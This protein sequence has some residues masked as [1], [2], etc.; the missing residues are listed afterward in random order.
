[1]GI[2]K[3]VNLLEHTI[4]ESKMSLLYTKNKDQ[5]LVQMIAAEVHVGTQNVSEQMSNYVYKRNK[6][7]IHYMDVS[8]TW[9]KLM[10]A[11][12]VIA[13][14]QAKNKQDVLIV[15]SRQYAQRAILKFGYPHRCQLLGW[16][17]GSR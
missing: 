1:M 12:R 10:V 9:E 16:K 3:V 17:V 6:D 8:K 5:D 7:G 4:N 2:I 14:P 13:A 11:A 15:S